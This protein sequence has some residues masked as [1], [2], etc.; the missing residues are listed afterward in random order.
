MTSIK[1][2]A[3]LV[4]QYHHHGQKRPKTG[5]YKGK[6][7]SK[8][9]AVAERIAAIEAAKMGCSTSTLEVNSDRETSPGESDKEDK[10]L[11]P[12]GTEGISTHVQIL[13]S[14]EVD[15]I[16]PKDVEYAERL[17]VAFQNVKSIDLA[18]RKYEYRT[19]KSKI[20][21]EYN[22]KYGSTISP[23][24]QQRLED[25]CYKLSF[26]YYASQIVVTLSSDEQ[27][28][29][30]AR[31]RGEK[32]YLTIRSKMVYT[33]NLLSKEKRDTLVSLSSSKPRVP[34]VRREKHGGYITM[35]DE[36]LLKFVTYRQPFDDRRGIYD[37]M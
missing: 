13:I 2:E 7:A 34:R 17:L 9:G 1:F 5:R 8:L 27:F 35:T 3:R 32:W 28:H 16:D 25:E 21:Q 23:A 19:R 31:K 12:Y 10:V 26:D 14:N 18:G 37:A 36:N 24:I 20:L 6:A 33:E 11:K 4:T 15:G 22:R 30:S 29:E